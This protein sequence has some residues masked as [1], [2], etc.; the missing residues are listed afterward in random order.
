MGASAP[1]CDLSSV[2]VA[3]LSQCSQLQPPTPLVSVQRGGHSLLHVCVPGTALRI[4][5]P[6]P[7]SGLSSRPVVTVT[8]DKRLQLSTCLTCTCAPADTGTTK[9][10]LQETKHS[11]TADCQRPTRPS[12]PS[13]LPPIGTRDVLI[14][15]VGEE[16]FARGIWPQSGPDRKFAEN[17]FSHETYLKRHSAL[18]GAFCGNLCGGKPQTPVLSPSQTLSGC[19]TC[20]P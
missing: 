20:E 1:M 15:G 7:G 8:S 4:P 19:L 5:G 6:T 13:P 17:S 18:W 3:C 16:T 9:G 10:H 2:Q 11:S 12:I 14:R